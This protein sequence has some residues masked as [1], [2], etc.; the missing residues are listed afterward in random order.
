MKRIFLTGGSGFLGWHVLQR[1]AGKYDL[2]CASHASPLPDMREIKAVPVDFENPASLKGMI[3]PIAP[4]VV[5]HLAALSKTGVCEENPDLARRI[6]TDVTGEI[7]GEIDPFKTRMIHISTD[8]V[9]DGS[10]GF[11]K[12]SDKPNPMMVYAKTK[13]E[14][15][16]LVQSRG[17]NYAILRLALMYGS[18]SPGHDSFLSWLEKGIALGSVVLFT[19]EYRTPLYARDAGSAI[20][21]LIESDFTGIMHLGGS[22]RCSRQEFGVEFA[23]QKGYP[24]DVII[25]KK[26]KDAPMKMYRPPD[27]SL[28]SSLA[29]NVLD[30]DPC[31]IREGISHYLGIPDLMR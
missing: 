25:G 23:R 15:E 12:E 17:G 27:V 31:S 14:A 19:D 7:L 18:G 22:Q 28:D 20:A 29:K 8:L 11:Y 6:N 9:F 1:L 5:I 21:S 3:M 16:K 2:W 26:L 24:V 13:L 10:K 4:D 30:I